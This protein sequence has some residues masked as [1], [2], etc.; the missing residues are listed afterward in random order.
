[1]SAPEPTTVKLLPLPVALPEA[2]TA[3]M[4]AVCH[5]FGKRGETTIFTV[6]VANAVSVPA[7]AFAV[8]MTVLLTTVVAIPFGP[9]GLFGELC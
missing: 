7:L 4:S 5:G 2:A 9:P 6:A 8:L 3:P 1:M